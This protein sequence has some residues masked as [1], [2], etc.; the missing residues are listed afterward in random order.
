M[1]PTPGA[2]ASGRDCDG[3]AM[4]SQATPATAGP[5]GDRR[6][7]AERLKWLL[8]ILGMLFGL[9]LATL[10]FRLRPQPGGSAP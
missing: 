8:P 10:G 2:R 5:V 3:A 9:G 7:R 1:P 4:I 6:R